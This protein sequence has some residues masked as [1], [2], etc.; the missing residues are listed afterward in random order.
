MNPLDP[1]SLMR[2]AFRGFGASLPYTL[3]TYLVPRDVIVLMYHA[4]GEIPA[5]HLRN[6]YAYK[7]PAQ[8]EEDLIHLKREFVLPTWAE[9][10]AS[11]NRSRRIERPRVLITF[12]DGLSD[13]FRVVRPLLLKHRIPCMF[14]VTK[15][16]VDNRIMFF[17]HKASL[18][19][20]GFG[21]LSSPDRNR[22]VRAAAAD[23]LKCP[24]EQFGFAS[25]MLGLDHKHGPTIDRVC[26]LLGIDVDDILKTKQPYLTSDEIKQLHADGFTIGGHSV[27]H[28][29]LQALPGE[30]V[31]LEIIDS[32]R[33]V[34]DLLKV[35]EVTFA[36]PFSADG[37]S[38]PNLRLLRQRHPWISAMF[39]S[40]GIDLDEPFL[41][42]RI[43]ADEPPAGVARSNALHLIKT[44][45]ANA[46]LRSARQASASTIGI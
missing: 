40:N 35:K 16:L 34:R 10:V 43:S 13:C 27:S 12:D 22:F 26:H 37:V 25:W 33:F 24:S 5:P 29:R 3:L 45:Y 28:P 36:F 15:A 21:K 42:N 11:G 9:F 4:V 6:L 31:E 30:E 19:I 7:T 44:S 38:R 46:L 14:F 17:R 23:G 2:T 18:C 41:F 20:E 32:C 8:F 1:K 39:G